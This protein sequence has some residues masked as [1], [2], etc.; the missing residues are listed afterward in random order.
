MSE[1]HYTAIA[2]E[3]RMVPAGDNEVEEARKLHHLA[4]GDPEQERGGLLT[5]AAHEL[6]H[7]L[8]RAEGTIKY[9]TSVGVHPTK[10][11]AL[12]ADE[13]GGDNLAGGPLE[14]PADAAPETEEARNAPIETAV[15]P[16][17]PENTSAPRAE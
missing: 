10:N 8:E 3:G 6:K 11:R 9:W 14:R 2:D 7:G 13:E 1:D 4:T 15:S 17:A 12:Y 16:D 5:G